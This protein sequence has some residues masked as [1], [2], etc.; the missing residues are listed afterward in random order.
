MQSRH[1]AIEGCIGAGKTT[2]GCLVMQRLGGTFVAENAEQNPFLSK[3]CSEPLK[4][5]FET[6]LTFLLVHYH[7][8]IHRPSGL[9]VADF[10][11]RKDLIFARMNLLSTDLKC[12]EALYSELHARLRIPDEVVFLN[13]PPELCLSRIRARAI[14]REQNIS[15]EY[16]RRLMAEY[17]L[18]LSELGATVHIV[19]V[20]EH[21]TANEIADTV[22]SLLS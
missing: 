15:L 1:I 17:Q 18:C 3:F 14:P 9:L 5:A 2:L 12:F 10:T 19:D 6:E 21:H 22:C 8:L 20:D 13:V 7:Q 16:L 11:F 4:Y